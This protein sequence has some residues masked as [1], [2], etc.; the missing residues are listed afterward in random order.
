MAASPPPRGPVIGF[1]GTRGGMTPEQKASFEAE[2]W[3]LPPG[4][5]FHHGACVGADEEA[6]FLV[7]KVAA[8]TSP[9][10]VAAH[11]GPKTRWDSQAAREASALCHG[12]KDYRPRNTDIVKACDVLCAGPPDP[13]PRRDPDDRQHRRQPRRAGRGLLARRNDGGAAPGTF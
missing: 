4:A 11:P 7:H 13:V 6:V 8:Q 2:L 12:R 5:A 10:W 3:A 9:T 1:T